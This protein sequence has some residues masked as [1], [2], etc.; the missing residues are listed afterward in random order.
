MKLPSTSNISSS[1]KKKKIKMLGIYKLPGQCIQSG[2]QWNA[3]IAFQTLTAVPGLRDTLKDTV[4]SH[5]L[6]LWLWHFSRIICLGNKLSPPDGLQTVKDTIQLNSFWTFFSPGILNNCHL[7][8]L[9]PY[10]LSFATH[11]RVISLRLLQAFKKVKLQVFGL[12]IFCHLYT[13][14]DSEAF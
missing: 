6:P 2:E 5:V 1:K 12:N 11:D 9:K 8:E 4:T 3:N 10:I 13:E 7:A 14:F